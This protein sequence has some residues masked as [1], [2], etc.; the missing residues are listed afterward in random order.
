MNDPLPVGLVQRIGDLDAEAQRLRERQRA[1]AEP[2]RQRLAF[3]ELHHEVLRAVLV[4]HVVKRADMRVRELRDGL[5]LA[6]EPLADLGG[7]KGAAAAP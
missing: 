1:L 7:K 6:L 3:Q 4:P 2:V 5:R